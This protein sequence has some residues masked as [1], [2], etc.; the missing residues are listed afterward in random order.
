MWANGKILRKMRLLAG[1][2]RAEVARRS[3]PLR[4]RFYAAVTEEQLR[5]W[6][7]GLEEPDLEHLET[8][9][10]LYGCPL[11]FFLCDRLPKGYMGYI[12]RGR[13]R[14]TVNWKLV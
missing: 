10:I 2:S 4:A 12:R 1:Y 11:G 14:D 7:E 9:S 6:E 5:L 13:Q 8:L 3:G